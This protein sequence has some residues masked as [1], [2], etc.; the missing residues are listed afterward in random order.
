MK[1]YSVSFGGITDK[2][3]SWKNSAFAVIPFPIDMTTTYM[4]GTRNG[5]RAIL[6]A[7]S[8]MELFDEENKIEPYRSGIFVS[9][10]VP[11]ATTG[12]IPMLKQ[13]ERRFRSVIK[14]GKFPV[15]LGGEHSGT[16]GAVAA[17]R[18]KYG[19]LTVLQFDAHAD[20]RDSYLGT[21]WNHACVGRRIVDSGAKLVQV[22][23]RSMSEEE[24]RFLKKSESVKTFYASEVRDNLADVTKGIVS[25]LSGN[26]YITFDLDVFDPG[27]MPSVGTPEPGGMSWF[28]AI[29]ILRDV[30][31][32]N[33]NIVGF[34]IMELAPIPG[35][36]AP[37]FLAAKLCYRMMGWVLAKREEK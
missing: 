15:L 36:V 34:D 14:A 19:E 28:E 33:C 24:D 16:C 12:P 9:T 27:I 32:S 25:S 4:A 23:I 30:M 6:D 17:L 11:L 10:E 2:Y 26:V 18:K 22:G 5:P 7:S 37:D 31:L 21:P 35:M 8:H 20:M 13:V 1:P 29:D 3:S